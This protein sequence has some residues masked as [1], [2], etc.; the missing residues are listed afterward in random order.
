[1][2]H[3]LSVNNSRYDFSCLAPEDEESPGGFLDHDIWR[4]GFEG[5]VLY[6]RL[7]PV[8]LTHSLATGGMPFFP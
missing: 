3:K 6:F 4:G 2:K 7:N 1:M 5:Y 8:C